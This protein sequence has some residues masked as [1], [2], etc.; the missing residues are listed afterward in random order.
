MPLWKSL[1]DDVR[2]WGVSTVMTIL[3]G[4]IIFLIAPILAAIK[5]AIAAEPVPWFAMFAVGLGGLCLIAIAVVALLKGKKRSEPVA[6]DDGPLTTNVPRRP[7]FTGP[8]QP[9]AHQTIKQLLEDQTIT[10]N[11][12]PSRAF[13]IE[14]LPPVP[15]TQHNLT[16]H[17]WHEGAK[18]TFDGDAILRVKNLFPAQGIDLVEFQ[19]VSLS[20]PMKARQVWRSSTQDTVLR[21]VDFS[22]VVPST[23][24]GGKAIDIPLF[25][26]TRPFGADSLE[27]VEVFFYGKWPEKSHSI[28]YPGDRHL[29]TVELTGNGVLR[30]EETFEIVFSA[31]K[32]K[33]VFTWRRRLDYGQG[34]AESKA[35]LIAVVDK[36]RAGVK[37]L[38]ALQEV[39]ADELDTND[40]LLQ[41]RDDLI[42][43]GHA[44]PF[45]A[46]KDTIPRDK[47]LEFLQAARLQ[48]LNLSDE[49][50]LL[51]L[52]QERSPHIKPVSPT[53]HELLVLTKGKTGLQASEILQPYKETWIQVEGKIGQL[54]ELQT[55]QL[56][57]VVKEQNT[58]KMIGCQFDAKWKSALNNEVNIGDN[59][60]LRGKLRP[61]L[62]GHLQLMRCELTSPS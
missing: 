39:H 51:D 59:V 20:P 50:A 45:Q 33:P 2:N 17:S 25:K 12:G 21:R 37:P 14:A 46:I 31:D 26:A 32:T 57:L 1:A 28:F 34:Q 10:I 44:D 38:R 54:Q 56:V 6:K 23:L 49:L 41:L 15:N 22:D 43:F 19:I 29:L 30:A 52:L 47:W 11:T 3:V 7:Y 53:A 4:G 55:G 48:G 61:Q 62:V 16:Q 8:A 18:I 13:D 27:G 35:M 42:K 60:K 5:K 36:L 40:M 58:G 24:K 9:R